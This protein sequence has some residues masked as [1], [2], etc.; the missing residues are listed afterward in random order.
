MKWDYCSSYLLS[1]KLL[2]GVSSTVSNTDKLHL[3]KLTSTEDTLQR[4]EELCT[5]VMFMAQ[6]QEQLE[7]N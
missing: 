4:L 7:L 2:E 5:K 6:L 1:E 3:K